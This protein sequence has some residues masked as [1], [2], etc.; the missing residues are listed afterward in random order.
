MEDSHIAQLDLP[1]G[2]HIFGVFDGHGGPEVA[3]FVKNHFVEQLVSS[4]A[5]KRQD[6]KQALINT[7][8]KMDRM[9]LSK[10]GKQE[11]QELIGLN[12][13]KSTSIEKDTM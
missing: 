7:F 13:E 1:A 2:N 5:Y 8:L 12:R 4:G 6:Y 3:L 10:K 11:I 9:L